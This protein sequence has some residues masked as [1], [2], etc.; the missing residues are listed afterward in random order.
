MTSTMSAR[1]VASTRAP[2]QYAVMRS[3]SPTTAP[4]AAAPATPAA[5]R[6]S[7][8]ASIRRRVRARTGGHGSR[9]QVVAELREARGARWTRGAE[10]APGEGRHDVGGG[11]GLTRAVLEQMPLGVVVAE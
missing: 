5:V 7:R 11:P 9:D 4:R 1:P 3:E 10:V 2:A 8:R 6:P